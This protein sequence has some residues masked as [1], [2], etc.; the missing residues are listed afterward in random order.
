MAERYEKVKQFT[1]ITSA[2][3][4]ST[5]LLTFQVALIGAEVHQEQVR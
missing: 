4:L 1:A 5:S 2:I 3:L